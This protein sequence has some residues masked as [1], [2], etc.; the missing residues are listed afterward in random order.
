MKKYNLIFLTLFGLFGSVSA[1]TT[2]YSYEDTQ[3]RALDMVSKGYVVPLVSEVKVDESRGRQK[4]VVKLS[5]DKV[6]N[7]FKGDV[8]NIRAYGVFKAAE[9]WNCDVVVAPTFHFCT[10][11]EGS[12]TLE[13]MGFAGTFFGWRSIQ[14]TDYDW[15]RISNL[16]TTKSGEVEAVVKPTT[17]R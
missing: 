9:E 12:W 8:V 14:D 1:Q 10:N 6:V 16:V 11:D 13:I 7:D 4:F 2:K 15:V 5:N 17:T 3:A